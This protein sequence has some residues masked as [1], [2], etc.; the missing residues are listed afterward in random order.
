MFLFDVFSFNAQNAEAVAVAR[1]LVAAVRAI[2]TREDFIDDFDIFIVMTYATP[3]WAYCP[4]SLIC[5]PG[6]S[7]SSRSSSAK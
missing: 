3:Y 6:G 5:S 7:S 4:I 1:R 2:V